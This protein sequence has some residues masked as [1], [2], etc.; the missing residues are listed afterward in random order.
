MSVVLYP[1]GRRLYGNIIKICSGEE[2]IIILIL[3]LFVFLFV[4]FYSF[5]LPLHSL[6]YSSYIYIWQWAG[7]SRGKWKQKIELNRIEKKNKLKWSDLLFS[8]YDFLSLEFFF[9]SLRF[10]KNS[11]WRQFS[12]SLGYKETTLY[13]IHSNSFS[14]LSISWQKSRRY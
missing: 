1:S 12:V 6:L 5:R 3:H 7:F 13:Y 8:I 2:W 11:K 14:L 9:F 10:L 4:L